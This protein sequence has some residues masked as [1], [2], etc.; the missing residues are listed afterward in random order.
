MR[1][2]TGTQGLKVTI[3]KGGMAVDESRSPHVARAA[4][5]WR[6]RTEVGSRRGRMKPGLA[7][8]RKLLTSTS[9]QQKNRPA[10]LMGTTHA[11]LGDPCA[12][13]WVNKRA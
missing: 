13:N 8:S 9:L 7:G 6:R 2:T 3:S 5:I 10:C 11:E 4:T 1:R 12:A